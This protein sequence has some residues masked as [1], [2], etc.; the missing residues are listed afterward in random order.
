[1]IGATPFFLAASFG[2]LEGMRLLLDGGADPLLRVNDGT[3]ALMVAAGADYVDGAD[4]YGRRW[5]GDNLALQR[6]A[7]ETI[8]FLLDLGL[9]V[10]DTND[11]EQTTLHAARPVPGRA[12][13]RHQR[14]QRARSDALDD[15]R[16]GG[17]PIRLLLHPE[18]NG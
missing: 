10:N 7:L 16:R 17:I 18:G 8:R 9:G 2:D 1:N 12:G 15:R 6:S 5:F 4:K 11:Y 13:R 14:D 3:T